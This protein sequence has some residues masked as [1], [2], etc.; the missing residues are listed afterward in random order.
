MASFGELVSY[1]RK[2]KAAVSVSE[3]EALYELFK[4]IS[5]AVIDDRLI[6]KEEFQL[7]LFKTNKKESLFAD[8]VFDLFDTTHN[9]ILDFEEFAR[10]LSVFHPNAPIDDK[11][12]CNHLS[13]YFLFLLYAVVSC[14]Y[15]LVYQ[16][17]SFSSVK[18]SY[19]SILC[20]FFILFT[21]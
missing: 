15:S 18:D 20:S 9:G 8:R 5:S 1:L 4:K 14:I 10:S 21:Y 12:E 11:I 6:N 13:F 7:V 2:G 19:F 16:Y 3:I 17:I